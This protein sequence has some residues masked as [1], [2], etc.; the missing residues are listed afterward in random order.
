VKATSHAK[1]GYIKLDGSLLT[2]ELLCILFYRAPARDEGSFASEFEHGGWRGLV[3]TN[4]L[5]SQI[6]KKKTMPSA[7]AR[8]SYNN[9]NAQEISATESV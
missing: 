5:F 6:Q 1:K 4:L 2:G 7:Y 9:A 8:K 3:A